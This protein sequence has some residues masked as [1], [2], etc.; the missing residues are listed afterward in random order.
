MPLVRVKYP[1][2]CLWIVGQGASEQLAARNDNVRIVVTG[3]VDDVRPYL[4]YADLTCVPLITGS[5]TKY[6][7]F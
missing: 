4:A 3:K 7:I 6:K 2:I 1:D 5:G